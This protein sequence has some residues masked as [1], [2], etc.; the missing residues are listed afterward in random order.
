MATEFSQDTLLYFLQSSGGSVKNS[1]LLLHFRHFIRDH[2]D[3]KRNREQ[4]KK[5]V[6]SLATVKQIDGVSYVILRKK[7]KGHVTGGG[8]GGS[9]EPPP[10]SARKNAEPSP[11]DAKL[12]PA[13]STEK[14]RQ[15]LREVTTPAPLGVIPGKTI[16]PAA[17]I[18]L[19]N[20]NNSNMERNLN[21]K[22]KRQQVISTPELCGRPAAA[23]AV[24]QISETAQVKTPGLSEPF[25]PDQCRPTKAQH[26]VGFGLPPGITPAVA[27]LRHHGE[28]S[29]QL[30][31][32]ETLR[33]REACPQPEGGLH[34]KPPLHP[35]SLQP[36]ASPR[37][38]RLRQS[39]KSAVS[40]DED[41]EEE[42][43]VQIRQCSAGGAR[44]LST[45]SASSPCILDP[46]VSPSVV[47]SSSERKLPEIYVQDVERETMT[48]RGPGW[49]LES[50]VGQR[51]Q[52][53]G[54]GLEPG[55][56]SG[57]STRQSLPLEAE[58]YMASPD[59]A[60]E[61]EVQIRQ[62]SAGGA[63]SL[64]TPLSD[65][66]RAIS[67][68]SPCIL[69]PP[70]SPSVVSSSSSSSSERKLP[71]NYVQDVERATMNPRGSGWSLE[72]GVGQRGLE[73]GSVSGEST[74]Q[75]LPLEA[76]RY[77]ASPDRATEVVPH[78]DAHADRRYSQPAGVRQGPNPSQGEWQSSSHSSIFSPSSDAGPSKPPP[79]G[80]GCNSSY[81]DLQA[82]AGETGGGSKIQ[83]A[84]ER[85][86]GE[87]LASVTHRANSKTTAPWHNSTGRLHD[88]QEP[89]ARLSP[90]HYSSDYL[91]DNHN[92]TPSMAPWHLSTGDIYD[93][94]EAES[95][96]GSTSSPP[97][98]LHPAVARQL[99][100]HLRSR[101]CRSLGADLDQLSQEESRAGG[102]SEAARL[103]R[104]HLIS[105]SLSLR[106][107]LSSSSLSSCSTPPRCQSLAD[108]DEGVKWRGGGGGGGGGRRSSPIAASST[109][110]LEG[111]SR[112]SMVPL[113]P[114]EHAW[115]VKGA[116]GAWPDIYT[117][118]R[119]D[120][121]LLNKQDFISG[122]TVLHW[123][124]KHGDHRVLNTLW[125]G[126]EKAGLTF[127]MNAKSTCGHTPL[128]IAAIHGNKNI[129]RLLV[130]KFNAD[131]KLRDTAGKKAWQY[132]SST[133]QPEVFQLLGA[134][135]RP[136]GGGDG[137]VVREDQEPRQ[138]TPR[139]RR[140]HLSFASSGERP[141]TMSGTTR[142]K[143]STSIA[144][145][146]KH[147]SLL[148]FHGHQSD[149]SV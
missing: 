131:V 117:L 6:N 26:R 62:C 24:S 95:S 84:L 142:V 148:Q 81:D 20:N 104:L 130:N 105:S 36:Q 5:F 73:P 28:T 34:Q 57:E 14:P 25:A 15:K 76:E 147:K 11:E 94:G 38:I 72:S 139:R 70:V 103:N 77:M 100:S 69:D 80:L 54:P 17:G 108:L 74:R 134:P 137:G 3:Q 59:R 31:V 79:R 40:C 71:E 47:S 115:L 110:R 75:S 50:G 16:L 30:P 48:P 33:G 82:R 43:E 10:L 90:F 88:D 32:P 127:N 141:L 121:S 86:Q 65:M 107:N 56:V 116:A 37:H 136:P 85:A 35:I 144:A 67:A 124:A 83:E 13:W 92:S 120:S 128:H 91:H 41:E 39:Y 122:F 45:I 138:Q 133:A 119:E 109:A 87:K 2:A 42:E 53:A 123:I 19:N 101:M 49:S 52:W 29:Q 113:E 143:R 102:G 44:P 78:H 22:Q 68:S 129:M 9:S 112:Q 135:S 145:F 111:P 99:S 96:E 27:A 58:R 106:Y 97:P 66:G 8:E 55:S 4:F 98:G 93:R 18:V 12:S 125:Y 118:F 61:E 51:G 23:Q 126:V 132:L 140:H 46:P 149:S 63:R 146:L 89:T 1:D 114:R 7:F 60:T 64:N 21:L